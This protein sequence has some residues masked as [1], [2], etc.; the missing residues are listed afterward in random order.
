M[1]GSLASITLV[2]RLTRDAELKYTNGGQAV[3]HFTVATDARVKK[4]EQYVEEGSF[5]EVD[6]WGK[7]GEAVNQYLT[8]GALV[9]VL[10]PVRLE[11]SEYEGKTYTRAKVTA[12]EL[13]LLGGKKQEQD[14]QGASAGATKPEAQQPV[15]G[16]PPRDD[17]ADDTPF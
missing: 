1:S 7:R 16:E 13:S 6:L 4:G 9:G 11:K 5:W 14:A 10:G 3:C 12:Q 2:G 17:F 15:L 8:K